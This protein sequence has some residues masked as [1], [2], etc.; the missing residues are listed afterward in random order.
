MMRMARAKASVTALAA[1]SSA[2]N[3]ED[4]SVGNGMVHLEISF[5]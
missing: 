4:D 1:K 5:A 2:A 3:E